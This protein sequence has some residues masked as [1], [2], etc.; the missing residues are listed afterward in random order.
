[1]ALINNEGEPVSRWWISKAINILKTDR[2]IFSSQNMRRARIEFIAGK[3]RLSTIK[4]WML[5]A[6]LI[7]NGKS[8]KEFELTDF[9]L[10]LNDNDPELNKSSTW[11]AFHLATCFSTSSEPYR[12]FF[13]HLDSLSKDW[14]D[15]KQ[16]FS[17]I[18]NSLKQDN[19]E[20]Y[21]QSTLESLNSSVRRMF[22]EDRPLADL[23]LIEIRKNHDD[24][25]Q[26]LIRLGSPQLTDEIIIH[27]LA[28]L[29]FH[30]FKNRDSVDFSEITAAGLAHF[31]C[32]SDEELRK[33]LRRM[34]QTNHWKEC[35]SFTEAVDLESLKFAG[36]CD[37]KKTLLPLLQSGDDTWL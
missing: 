16:L 15:S 5:A 34:N 2:E 29:K 23:G 22:Q 18:H 20:N 27:A 37:P 35:F 32:C 3:N 25:K 24:D 31:L 36:Q 13:Y 11:W 14:I 10:S 26:I 30:S 9:G 4:G 17:K 33:H 21:K 12:S 7:R 1:M 6:Q 28:M 19:G 8:S